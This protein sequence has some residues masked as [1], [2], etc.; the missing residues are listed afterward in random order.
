MT[1][2]PANL[3]KLISLLE[4]AALPAEFRDQAQ[5][6]Q[7]RLGQ[8]QLHLAVLGQFKRGKSTVINALLGEP[9]LPDG[10]LPV[11]AVPV[12]LYAAPVPQLH[13]YTASDND[14][15]ECPLSALPE[16]VT[17]AGNPQNHKAVERVNL[18]YPAPL[19]QTGIV[20]ID[21]PGVGSTNENNTQTTLRFLPQCDAA[22]VVFSTDP[23]ITAAEV[24]FLRTVRP[25]IA[26]FFFVLNKVDYLQPAEVTK[27]LDFLR[28][29]LR[30]ALAGSEPDIF[31]VSARRALAARQDGDAAGWLASGMERFAGE[32]RA[33]AGAKQ[34]AILEQ[35]VYRKALAVLDEADQLLALR[36]EALQLPLAQ[37][38]EKIGAFHGYA[39][40]ARRQRE[41]ID[42]RL[43]GDEKRLRSQIETEAPALRERAVAALAERLA[44]LDLSLP[45]DAWAQ[46]AEAATAAFYDEA[47]RQWRLEVRQELEAIASRR[48]GEV[49]ALREQLRHNAADLL[50]VPHAPRLEEETIIELPDPVWV[51][52][53]F[54]PLPQEAPSWE[55]LLAAARQRQRQIQRRQELVLEL[56]NRNTERVR[57]WLLQ[58]FQESVR[59]MRGRLG[60]TV[61]QTIEQIEQALESARRQH[62]TGAASRQGALAALTAQRHEFAAL[63]RALMQGV[64]DVPAGQRSERDG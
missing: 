41:D 42:D 24:D 34:Q 36:R 15:L 12:F 23:P 16:Y 59:H 32:L 28:G 2:L 1:I 7:A 47:R 5:A 45:R 4:D 31:A 18:F 60:E 48:A 54:V 58:M 39:A 25:H 40:A 27:A 63:R 11:T 33:F 13:V 9:L 52:G 57:W 20:L 10:V 22:I 29:V 55:R 6:L 53:T 35:A 14:P 50:H 26:H 49:V 46:Q 37:L 8:G 61:E 56:A 21:T 51:S 19:L 38:E 3:D 44:S 17:E 64:E 30:E 43:I 62:E